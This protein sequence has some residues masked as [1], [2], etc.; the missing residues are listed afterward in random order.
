LVLTPV[1]GKNWL[2][3]RYYATKQLDKATIIIG[4]E[5]D[6]SRGKNEYAHYL[7]V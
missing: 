1:E 3:H 4:Q 6:R 7:L 5:L 2:M